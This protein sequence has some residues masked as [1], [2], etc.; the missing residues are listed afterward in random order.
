M[1][2]KKILFVCHLPP[3]VHGSSMVGKYLKDSEIIGSSFD[4]EFINLSTSR[5]VNEIGKNPFFKIYRYIL[6]ILKFFFKIISYNPGIVYLA[7]TA[8]GIGF[9]KDFPLVLITKLFCKKLVLHYHNKGVHLKQHLF[10][11]D[12]MYRFLFKKTKVI[13]LAKK[14]YHD[15]AKYVEKK[16]VFICPNGIPSSNFSINISD[17]IEKNEVPKLLFL[18]NLI[19]SKGVYI[20]LEALNILNVKGVKFQCNFVGGEGDIS[21]KRLNSKI[22]S[23]NLHHC[24]NYL[25]KKYD[26]DKYEIFHKSNIFILPT[27]YHNEC[28]P[29]V[30]LEAMQ[31]GL[32]VITSDEG[33]ISEIVEN[34][35]NGFVLDELS[36]KNLA[37]KIKELVDNTLM[38]K[39]MGEKGQKKFMQYYTLE[40]FEKR[41]KDI[42]NQILSS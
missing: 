32:P 40:V 12:L 11:Y 41:M 18:S 26:R 1:K 8:K 7:I 3:P 28:F 13:L 22:L 33:G 31:Y 6:I 21:S 34:N 4:R 16:N 2:N 24:V 15:I 39:N 17:E 25:G 9:F 10:F 37:Q 20:L 42:L 38:S 27:Y 19:K 36:P 29:L 35:V 23:L 5:T 14:L 30:V